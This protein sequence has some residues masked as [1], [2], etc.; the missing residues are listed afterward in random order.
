MKKHLQVL[1]FL[2]LPIFSISQTSFEI[3]EI[4]D[5]KYWVT[6]SQENPTVKII[7]SPNATGAIV[8]PETVTHQGITYHVTDIGTWAFTGNILTSVTIPGSVTAIGRFA[9][10]GNLLEKVK[11]KGITPVTIYSETFGNHREKIALII[12]E[13]TKSEYGTAG[14][15][16]FKSITEDDDALGIITFEKDHIN[17]RVTSL[18]GVSPTVEIKASPNA[19]G[20]IVIIPETVT[21]QGITYRVT[22][23]GNYAFRDNGLTSVIIPD[24]VSTIGRFAFDNNG[25]TSVIIPDSVTAIGNFAF[26]YNDLTSVTIPDSVISIGEATFYNNALEKVKTK[27]LTPATIFSNTFKNR[28]EIALIIPEGTKSV[29][30]SAGWTGFKSITEDDDELGII[31]FEIDHINYRVTSLEGLSPTVEIK[32]S[33]TATGAIDIPE[34]VTHEDIIYRVTVIGDEA[35]AG[36]G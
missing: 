36:N 20:A 24:S 9:F 6:S 33:P 18:E 28:A 22:A 34:T 19:T 17:Y 21:H 31:T 14:W 23:I 1:I 11:A 13:G 25:L 29:Y 4:D 26:R 5:I 30:K 10:S 7:D 35:F 12:P 8:I 3:F 15:T 2:M 27:G 16:G 32:E